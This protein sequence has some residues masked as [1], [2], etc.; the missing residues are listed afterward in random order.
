MSY[1]TTS[2]TEYKKDV[3]RYHFFDDPISSRQELI[4]ALKN[5]NYRPVSF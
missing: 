2:Y 5:G 1:G 4:L 3:L